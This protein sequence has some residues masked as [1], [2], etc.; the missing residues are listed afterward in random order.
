LIGFVKENWREGYEKLLVTWKMLRLRKNDPKLFTQG[1]YIPINIFGKETEA[2][3]YARKY[4]EKQIV[5]VAPLGIAS[6]YIN[7]NMPAKKWSGSLELPESM[8]G[9]WKNIFTGESFITGGHL[10]LQDIFQTFPVA[11]LEKV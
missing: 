10:S 6:R 5:V 11:V 8:P 3:A 9:Q 1:E 7:R 2:I 4:E